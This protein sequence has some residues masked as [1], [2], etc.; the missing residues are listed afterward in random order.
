[1]S[2]FMDLLLK[3]DANAFALP[4]A[5]IRIKRFSELFG[6]DATMTVRAIPF[7]T[8][9]DI[10]ESAKGGEFRLKMIREGVQDFDFSAE[11]LREKLGV[12][13]KLPSIEVIKKLFTAGEI[14]EIYL[15]ISK[16]SGYGADTVEEIKKK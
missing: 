10:R 11:A 6:K 13:K 15:M 4:T 5:K 12:D 1:M 8:I 3:A 14:E 2:E 9:E 16:I 7:E